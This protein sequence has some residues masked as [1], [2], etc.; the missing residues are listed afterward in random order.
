MSGC[1][2]GGGLLSRSILKCPACK[3]R[4]R[5]LH[6][7]SFGGYVVTAFCGHCGATWQDDGY[8]RHSKEEAEHY[9]QFVKNNWKNANSLKIVFDVL[10]K[11]MIENEE[12]QP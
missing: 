5:V 11:E 7:H 9:K 8:T 4:T 12:V 3:K 10:L 6:Q 2:C 1:I